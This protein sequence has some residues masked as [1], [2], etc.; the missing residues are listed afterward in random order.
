MMALL[1]G[2]TA[3]VTGSTKGIGRAI[4]IELS[5][6]GAR[7]LITHRGCNLESIDREQETLQIILKNGGQMP[8]VYHA[9]MTVEEDARKLAD[10]ALTEFGKVDIWVNNVG[11]HIVSPAD[12][13][14]A[15][16]WDDQFRLN[17]TST[18]IGCR[19]AARVMRPF[20]GAIINIASKMGT[21]GS[22]ENSCY[23]S[24]KAA[25][26]MMSRCLSVEW[27]SAGIRVNVIAPGV[28]LTDQRKNPPSGRFFLTLSTTH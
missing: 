24:A 3:V 9:D 8:L 23:C 25:V 17:T 12:N 1:S 27:A 5:K 26:I 2:K 22:P 20:G 7:V 13:L 6:E 4:A 18:F 15:A 10:F 19:E 16:E 28:T 21:V 14:T 11:K